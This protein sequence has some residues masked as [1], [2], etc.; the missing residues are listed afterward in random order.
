LNAHRDI[1]AAFRTRPA[2]GL[3]VFGALSARDSALVSTGTGAK[4]VE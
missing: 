2:A 1:A 4:I 3:I